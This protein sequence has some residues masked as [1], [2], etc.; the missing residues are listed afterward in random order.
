MKL[1]LVN[2]RPRAV[3]HV[4]YVNCYVNRQAVLR[5][6]WDVT[7]FLFSILN[8]LFLEKKKRIIFVTVIFNIDRQ[9]HGL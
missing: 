5:K 8:L 7:K 1:C 9:L 4:T 2:R 6:E 3:R